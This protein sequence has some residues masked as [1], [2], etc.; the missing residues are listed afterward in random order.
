[1]AL[2]TD[3]TTSQ[4]TGSVFCGLVWVFFC[5]EGFILHGIESI[6]TETSWLSSFCFLSL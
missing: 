4:R 5:T 1:M 6:S 2:S 3:H